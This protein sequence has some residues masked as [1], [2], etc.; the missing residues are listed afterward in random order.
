MRLIG[1]LTL[2][3]GLPAAYLIKERAPLRHTMFVDWLVIRSGPTTSF[4]FLFSLIFN[5]TITIIITTPQSSS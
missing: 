4:P 5:T 1:S 2:A 3:T